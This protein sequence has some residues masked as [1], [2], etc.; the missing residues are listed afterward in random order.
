MHTTELKRYIMTVL[1][2]SSKAGLNEAQTKQVLLVSLD[3]GLEEVVRVMTEEGL[4][5]R[6]VLKYLMALDIDATRM[7]E[8][9]E[10]FEAY[11]GSECN[12]CLRASCILDS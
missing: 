9:Q 2:E 11:K 8:I 7:R 1:L 10:S 5:L 12:K 6:G 3:S 4:P